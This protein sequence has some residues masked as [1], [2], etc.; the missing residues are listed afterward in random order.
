MKR[1]FLFI[2]FILASQISYKAT[3]VLAENKDETTAIRKLIE[4]HLGALARKDLNSMMSQISN[5]YSG[6]DKAG[7]T[8]DYAKLKS[9]MKNSLRNIE[10]ISISDLKITN[11]NIQDDKATLEMEYIF[12]GFNSATAKDVSK[13]QKR[14][15]SLVKEGGYW[16]IVNLKSITIGE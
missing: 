4:G 2:I 6:L 15:V 12:R 3:P 7:N 13:R 9:N 11:L 5:K 14:A 8:V 1:L 16:K 10:N